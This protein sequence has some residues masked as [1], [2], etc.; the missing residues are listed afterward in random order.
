MIDKV[1]IKRVKFDSFNEFCERARDIREVFGFLIDNRI[2]TLKEYKIY[3]YREHKFSNKEERDLL[4]KDKC[5]LWLMSYKYEP[6]EIND[7]YSLLGQV[8]K[9]VQIWLIN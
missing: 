3:L 6:M 2:I 1:L 5:W 7:L 4:I 8:K 9:E